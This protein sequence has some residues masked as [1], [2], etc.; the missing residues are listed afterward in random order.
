MS[1]KPHVGGKGVKKKPQVNGAETSSL[2]DAEGKGEILVYQTN[3]G[4]VR[5][6]VRLQEESVWLTQQLMAELFQ[7][8]KQ[9]I[10]QNQ[11]NIFE[12]GELDQDSVVKNLFTTAADENTART[13]I[14]LMP[15]FR[16]D[17]ALKA[18]LQ[19]GSGSGQPSG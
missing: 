18:M 15:L 17:T 11:K 6:D 12:K 5:L 14:T 7:T 19:H 2:P 1:D 8:S 10:G 16:W 4:S 3:D 13:S 9:N